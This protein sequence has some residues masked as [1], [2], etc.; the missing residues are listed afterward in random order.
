[1]NLQTLVR[2]INGIIPGGISVKDFSVVTQIDKDTAEKVL[3]NLMQNG[4]G[5][6]ENDSIYFE[7]NDKL[8]T[9]LLAIR[10]GAAVD[11]ISELLSWQDFEA[12]A[13]EILR[14]DNFDTTRNLTLTKPRMEIDV[15]GIKSDVAILID[16]KHWKR[17]SQAALEKAVK[18][19]IER[20]KQYLV[21]EKIRAAVPAIVTLYQEQIK[22]ID[23][24]PIIPIFQL[25]SFCEEFYGNLDE[26][27]KLEHGQEEK[28]GS[29]YQKDLR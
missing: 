4:I 2:G 9:S 25:G 7:E 16:C 15:V 19:Q 8:K 22:F 10:M 28:D 29:P 21:K 14:S 6:F 18:K 17:S 1:M 27:N 11:E 13:E 12:L 24:V 23:K 26:M 20:T 3:D 5:R